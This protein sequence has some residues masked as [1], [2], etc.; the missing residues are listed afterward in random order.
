MH[1]IGKFL[2]HAVSTLAATAIGGAVAGAQGAIASGSLDK[3]AL[4]TAAVG[5]A[6]GAVLGVAQAALDAVKAKVAV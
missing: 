6:V 2:R 5:G 4:V 1:Y 3:H